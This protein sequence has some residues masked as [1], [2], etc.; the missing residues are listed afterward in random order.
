MLR[1]A[2]TA[3]MVLRRRGPLW[4][5]RLLIKASG[6]I[7]KGMPRGIMVEPAQGC[8]GHCTGCVR[9]EEPAAMEPSL[10]EEWLD[11][12]PCR[13][14]T[15]HF[16]G[17]HSDPLASPLLQELVASAA[18]RCVM[19]SISTIGLGMTDELAG[20]DVDRWIVSIPAATE[21]SWKPLRNSD[22]F[23]EAVEAIDSLHRRSSAMVEVVLTLWRS[24]EGDT[25]AFEAL[26]ALHGWK[27]RQVVFGRYDP[28]GY[29]IG[30]AENLALGHPSSPY[31]LSPEG[32]PMLLRE[33]HGCPLAG[34]LFLTAEG[35]LLPCPFV[36]GE[37]PRED[38]PTREAWRRASQWTRAKD[39]RSFA[40]CRFCP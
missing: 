12:A 5:L 2:A 23:H 17:R 6:C 39:S 16:T 33:P 1:T 14:V 3:L 7:V 31:R 15:V 10:L 40:A 13:P 27:R 8:T 34:C 9:P 36:T 21:S 18:E 30:R 37:R 28:E 24:S 35:F 29:S 11:S 19:T 38:R 4:P 32:S 20:T 26:A 25:E 22:V